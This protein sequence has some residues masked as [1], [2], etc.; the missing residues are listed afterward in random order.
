VVLLIAAMVAVW[1][2]S[3]RRDSARRTADGRV[4]S[5]EPG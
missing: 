5:E 1:I 4:L 3:D 2:V